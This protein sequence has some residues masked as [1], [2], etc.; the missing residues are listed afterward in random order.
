[1]HEDPHIPNYGIPGKGP[2][3]RQA[4]TFAIEPMVL[5]G[6]HEVITLADQ[7]TVIAKD[8]KLTAHFEHTVVVTDNGPEILTCL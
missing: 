7:W 2:L 4:M 1:M 5:Q 6:N 3:L 8:R